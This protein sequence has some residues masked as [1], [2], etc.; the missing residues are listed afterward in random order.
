M[1][2]ARKPGGRL[3]GRGTIGRKVVDVTLRAWAAYW[4]R[5]AEHATIAILHGLDDRALKDIGLDRSEIESVVH[6]RNPSERR[7]CWSTYSPGAPRADCGI[8]GGC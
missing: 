4:A 8:S 7:V 2:Q 3:A 5:R 1:G 6:R